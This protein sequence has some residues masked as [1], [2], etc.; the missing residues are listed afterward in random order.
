M[1]RVLLI[2]CAVLALFAGIAYAS[3]PNETGQDLFF[4]EWNPF[5]GED[6][7]YSEAVQAM[8]DGE[9]FGYSPEIP[10]RDTLEEAAADLRGRMTDRENTVVIGFRTDREWD[11]SDLSREIFAMAVDHTGVP[12]EG[13]SL[14]WAWQSRDIRISVDVLEDVNYVTVAY[15]LQYY[16][17]AE[18]ERELDGAVEELLCELDLWGKSDY[19]KIKGI[20]DY[21]CDHV[22]YDTAH[23]NQSSYTLKYTPYAALI[24][25]TAVCQGFALLYYRLAC[26]LDVDTRV[27]F[28]TSS[29]VNHVWMIVKDLLLVGLL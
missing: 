22:K 23:A 15:H 3:A 25:K 2:L 14:A 26:E 8:G 4:S 28:G 13:D 11:W 5:Y 29:R 19:E 1:K 9:D 16:T 12:T 6:P 7:F 21:I 27:I 24:R 10:Y 20:Y 17:T 18:M